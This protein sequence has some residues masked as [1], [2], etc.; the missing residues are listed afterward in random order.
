MAEYFTNIAGNASLRHRLAH[1]IL[2][3]SL[4]HAYI[5]EGAEGSGRRTLALN[6]AAALSCTHRD[7]DVFP[8]LECLACR[9]ILGGKTPDII[10]ITAENGRAGIGV[11]AARFIRT[12]TMTVPN[13]F[14]FKVYI[15][16]NADTMTPQAQNALLLTLEEP[17]S[18][19]VFFLICTSASAL[20]E[21]V[22][23]RAPIIRTELLDDKLLSEYIIAHDDRARALA[24]NRDEFS[25]MVSDAHGS[26]GRALRLLDPKQRRPGAERHQLA[27]KFVNCFAGT[28]SD[29][30][31]L[32]MSYGFSAK[33]DDVIAE[34]EVISYALRD[35]IL[36]KKTENAPLCFFS[37]RDN[38]LDL[39]DRFTLSALFRLNDKVTA[40]SDALMRNANLRLTIT[41]LIFG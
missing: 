9:K 19:A 28:R 40:A 15:I 17:H 31:K 32:E 12:D 11:E 21:T 23:S 14:D 7:G 16:E 25:A 10:R 1:D 3:G 36:L 34:L 35:L 6:I 13:D 8:C 5:I 27:E 33:R 29:A 30:A 24:S 39:A 18:Y 22:R 37:D 4:P 20:L 41:S 2:G 38:A 26:I